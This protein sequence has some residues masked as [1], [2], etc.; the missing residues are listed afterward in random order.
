MLDGVDAGTVAHIYRQGGGNPFYLEQLARASDA[1]RLPAPSAGAGNGHGVSGVPAAVSAL[2][3]GEIESLPE[4]TR[5]M[6]NGAAVA[7]EPFEPD[8]AAAAAK[9]S[10]ED[11]LTALDDLLE[12][13]L[14]RPTQVPAALRVP[15]SARAPGRVRV[16][17]RG[18]AARRACARG[19]GA[20][21]PRRG[22]G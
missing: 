17:S 5:A 9:L 8:L 6:L 11:G 13:D 10:E 18:L 16:H 7:G 4:V 22:A 15:P 21:G 20:R 1:G 12:L 2:L 19:R 3:A 14:V